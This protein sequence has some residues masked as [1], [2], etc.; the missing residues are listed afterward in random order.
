MSY[1]LTV[2]G[3]VNLDLIVQVDALPRAGETV[4]GG[5]YSALPG[6]KG[7]NVAVAAKRLGAETEIM[8]AVGDDDYAAQALVNLEKEGVYLDA[9]RRLDA[10]TGLAFITV[11]K[12]GENQIAV[13]SGANA[14]YAPSDVPKLCSDVLI[15]QFEIPIPVIE[16]ALENYKGFVAVNASPVRSGVD[17][18]LSRADL[19]ILNEGEASKYDLSGHTGLV[20][21]TLGSEGAELR[22]DGK[23]IATAKPPKVA[24][25][26]TTGAGDA[27]AAAL[28]VALAE[29]QSEQNALEFACAVGALTTTKLGTQTASPTRAE[30]DEVLRR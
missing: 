13:A 8:A 16:G 17:A 14:A 29:K 9:V 20:A 27:F 18:I 3:S 5:A 19:I 28:T 10:H 2:L 24:V 23:I 12:D 26:D 4:T 6:G 1:G 25:I 22:R 21:V 11:S 30:V 7:A 15:T